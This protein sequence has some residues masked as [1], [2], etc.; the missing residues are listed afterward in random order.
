M[1]ETLFDKYGG[2]ETFSA[3]VRN[4]YTKVL[5]SNLLEPYFRGTDMN[6]LMEHQTNFLAKVLGGP[7][8]YQGRNILSAHKGLNISEAAFAEVAELLSDALEEA[9]IEDKDIEYIIIAVAQLKDQ[10]VSL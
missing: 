3:V 8:L 1:S 6:H 2:I 9:D 7:D 4:F 10:I 5:D